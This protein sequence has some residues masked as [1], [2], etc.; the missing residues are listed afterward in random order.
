MKKEKEMIYSQCGT[1]KVLT[2]TPAL[3]VVAIGCTLKEKQPVR[4]L[5]NLFFYHFDR[6]EPT[7]KSHCLKSLDIIATCNQLNVNPV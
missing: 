6:S 5:L 7:Y 1:C 3:S 4:L 2:K